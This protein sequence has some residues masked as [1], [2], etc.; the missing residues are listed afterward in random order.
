MKKLAIIFL[1]IF[2]AMPCLASTDKFLGAPLLPGG[3]V[4]LKS[5]TRLEMNT[6][7]SHDEVIAFYKDSLKEFE[8]IKFRDWKNDTYIEDDGALKWHSITVSKNTRPTTVLIVK[9]NWS[10]IISTLLLRFVAVFVVLLVLYAGMNIS[11]GII[12][13]MINKKAAKKA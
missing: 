3:D 13:R 6:S 1:V 10:W 7:M 9:D 4:K 8:N 12:S 11:G 5:D 2:M